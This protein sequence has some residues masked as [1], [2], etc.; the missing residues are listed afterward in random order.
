MTPKR[1]QRKRTK[2]YKQPPGTCYCGRGTKCGNDYKIITIDGRVPVYFVE[3]EITGYKTGVIFSMEAAHAHAV[4]MYENV[5]MK[6]NISGNPAYYDDLLNY[7]NLSCF[8]PLD[9]P[10]HVDVIIKHLE[11]RA[12]EVTE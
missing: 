1:I 9:M 11:G 12:N 2:G 5:Q 4:D 7:E 10:C 3:N 6:I 8:C